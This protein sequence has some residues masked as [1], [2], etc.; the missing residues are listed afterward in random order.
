MAEEI[1]NDADEEKIGP[2]QETEAVN[3]APQVGDGT[4][5]DESSTLVMWSLI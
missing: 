4:L 5:A 2:R 1:D 3:A